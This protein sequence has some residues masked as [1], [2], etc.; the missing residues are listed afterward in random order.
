MNGTVALAV[1]NS[2][3]VEVP[4]RGEYVRV[5]IGELQRI[6]HHLVYL[7]CMALDFNGYT[8]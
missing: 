5:N 6:A 1:W 2:S 3:G 4:E 8:V 7:A